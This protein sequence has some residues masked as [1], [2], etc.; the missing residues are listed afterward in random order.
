MDER[1]LL[2]R[3]NL[4]IPTR[5][6]LINSNRESEVFEINTHNISAGGAF[7]KTSHKIPEGTHINMN[8]V[9]PIERLTK[10]LGVNSFIKIKGKIIRVNVEGIAVSF[11]KKYE[12]LPFKNI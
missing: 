7:F 12:I 5:I 10:I 11:D 8:F 4:V 2:E 9:L 1:R 6:E 3:Y